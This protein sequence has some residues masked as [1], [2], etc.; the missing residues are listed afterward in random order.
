[1]YSKKN[2]VVRVEQVEA[3]TGNKK[4][5]SYRLMRKIRETLGLRDGQLISV[6]HF[7]EYMGIEENE[8]YIGISGATYFSQQDK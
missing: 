7:C 4:S 8:Y 2:R 3:Y 6:S 1:M 5:A